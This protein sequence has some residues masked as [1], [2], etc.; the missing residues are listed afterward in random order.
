MTD[1]G[2]K[3]A[4]EVRGCQDCTLCC[5]LPEI[6][7]F[8][9]PA[10]EPCSHCTGHGCAAYESRPSV[11]RDFYCSWIT[12]DSLA[13]AWNPLQSHMMVYEQGAQV[14]VLVDPAFPDAWQRQPFIGDMRRWAA[15]D[16]GRYVIVFVGDNVFRIRDMETP[17]ISGRRQEVA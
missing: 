8:D 4:A 17:D 3:I 16:D 6:D 2:Q 7:V 9:K 11:C 1:V 13:D 10:N 15:K 14:T 12:G 5:R